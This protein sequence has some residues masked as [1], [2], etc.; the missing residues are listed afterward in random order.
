MAS[1]GT[2]YEEIGPRSPEPSEWRSTLAV[3]FTSKTKLAKIVIVIFLVAVGLSMGLSMLM[4]W[5]PK[6]DAFYPSYPRK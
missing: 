1:G 4:P 2:N 3:C 6:D 5:T